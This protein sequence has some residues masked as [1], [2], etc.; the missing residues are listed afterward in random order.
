MDH[1]Q[2]FDE[3]ITR[4]NDNQRKAVDA[5]DG[6]V[7]VI[8]GPGTG[9][10]QVIAARI[11]NILKETDSG[12]ENIL[13]LTYTDAATIAMRNRLIQFIGPTA[14]NV[15][16]NTFHAFCNN[17]I[18]DNIRYFGGIRDLQ[19][20][21]ELEE[22]ELYETML[23]DLPNDHILKRLTG[24]TYYERDRL[25]ILFQT[26]KKENWSSDFVVSR[27]DRYLAELPFEDGM[28]YKKDMPKQNKKKGD[29]KPD[30]YKAVKQMEELK[31]AALL[32]DEYNQRLK[33]IKRY[34]FHDM[35]LWVLEAFENQKHL[36]LDYQ[37]RF[38]FFLVDE[39]QDTNGAQNDLLYQLCSYW[40]APNVFV[41]GD[42]DQSIYRF[43][44]ANMDNI[45]AYKEK[46]QSHLTEIVLTDNY[47]STQAILDCA[48]HLILEGQERLEAVYPEISKSLTARS[49]DDKG[50]LPQITAYYNT[51]HEKADLIHELSK[52]HR[53]G[54]DLSEIAVIYRNHNQVDDIVAALEK[55][56]VP[57]NLKKK[58]DVL[59]EVW[60]EQLTDILRYIKLEGEAAF[61]G[62]WLLPQIMHYR[63]FRIHPLDIARIALKCGY[64]PETR[65][66]LKWREI[67]SDDTALSALKLHN[68]KAIR[69]FRDNIERWIG[70]SFNET[71]QVLFQQILNYGD[72]MAGLLT[73]H[74]R[75]WKMQLLTTF[76]DFIKEESRRISFMKV[77]DLVETIDKMKKY[78]IGL[79]IQRIIYN[80]GGVNFVTAHS[81]KGL[82]FERVYI[83]GAI[84]N[85]WEGKR[86]NTR[87]YKLPPTIFSRSKEN[88]LEDERRLFYVGMTRAKS[89][90]YLSY[91]AQTPDE[92]TL[93]RS[94]F[95]V[96]LESSGLVVAP[97]K[98]VKALSDEE[99]M[100][101]GMG[102][103]TLREAP[104]FGFIDN[105]VA[106][107]VLEKFRLSVTALNKYLQC[108]ISFYFDNI[109]KVPSA[110]TVHT[111]FGQA[112]HR[113]LELMH[114]ESRKPDMPF[115]TVERM[116]ELFDESMIL[117]HSH[118]TK[119]EFEDRSAFGH[120][121][122]PEYYK[123]YVPEWQRVTDFVMEY[124]I[125][126]AV[127]NDV[128]IKGRLDRVEVSKNEVHVIDYKTGNRQSPKTK[129]NLKGPKSPDDRGGDYWRQIVYYR[130]LIENDTRNNWTFR[131]GAF[132]FV[133][134]DKN[135]GEFTIDHYQ[136]SDE[137]MS[138]VKRQITESYKAI[139]NH[140]FEKGCGEEDCMWCN[141]VKYNQLDTNDLLGEEDDEGTADF[142]IGEA[143]DLSE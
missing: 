125:N 137:E 53:V 9:K 46:Y 142:I 23:D 43:Q 34:D 37:E 49:F 88:V 112:I 20:I 18:Q 12:P 127:C 92:K 4:L 107:K 99:M 115:P 96:E 52:A 103:L 62:E 13:C 5:L 27:T 70:D 121:F 109:L 17:V 68:P 132:D 36:L 78:N 65:K 106:E 39:Y 82:E 83:I 139:Q 31:A 58:I 104:R 72:I 45:L 141:F 19:V 75:A 71:V 2:A 63:Y 73:T 129:S 102:G 11:G 55:N 35:I 61:S 41:V 113:T 74:D 42:D 101:Y 124:N 136:V 10:T 66:S 138:V 91:S 131:S 22:V 57:L 84:S 116:L 108:P 16:I 6:P 50:S 21:N 111:G 64:D 140:E 3:A 89:S 100:T 80:P 32:F 8:A 28:R 38:H 29:F 44:G 117:Y 122:L 90:L 119:K 48:R 76:F 95:L 123:R 33:S 118:F 14:Y 7:M 98:N 67:L 110:R 130:I 93:Q 143:P 25:K 69:T 134:P 59:Q 114:D 87:T 24:N 85:K 26:M 60:I 128:P 77:G 126:Q 81:S 135:T 47:R 40:E 79:P 1:S 56:G 51:E 120:K 30:Y 105:D 97:G 133:Q 86:A 15:H 54:E 94:R